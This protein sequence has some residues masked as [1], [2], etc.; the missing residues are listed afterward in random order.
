MT[1]F[2]E[3][4]K[5]VLDFQRNADR[6]F[7]EYNKKIEGLREKYRPEVYKQEV[8]TNV[9]PYYSGTIYSERESAK[10]EISAICDSIREDLDKW[11]LRPVK[12]E[13]LQLLSCI[14]EFNIKLS[15]DELKVIEESVEENLFAKKAFA[16]IAKNNGYS[17]KLPDITAYLRA[18]RVAKS[19]ASIAIDAYCG[20]A[21][22]FVGKDLL[23]KQMY[24]GVA[25]GEW[26][27]WHRL[28]AADYSQKC[29]SL[30][31]AAELWEKARVK[32]EYTLTAKERDRLKQIAEK[33]T[34]GNEKENKDR[35]KKL[36]EAEPDI[37]E[38]FMLMGS[39]YQ[40][41]IAGYVDTGKSEK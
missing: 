12:T 27:I 22:D 9:W 8:M 33:N 36:M 30:N 37:M 41:M 20:S 2:E 17:V 7:A 11:I 24:N 34:K 38:K 29:S 31:E 5:T 21:P 23:D 4:K 14:R 39:D 25:V 19:D 13:T 35:M 28:Y 6:L 10:M 26:Q 3:I 32:T 18:L 15:R 16:E 1:K 40:E